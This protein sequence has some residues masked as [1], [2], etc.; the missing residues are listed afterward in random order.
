M[1]KAWILIFLALAIISTPLTASNLQAGIPVPLEKLIYSEMSPTL[2]MANIFFAKVDGGLNRFPSNWKDVEEGDL[3]RSPEMEPVKVFRFRSEG[4]EFHYVV[5]DGGQRKIESLPVLGFRPYL[6]GLLFADVSVSLRSKSATGTSPINLPYQVILSEKEGYAYSRIAEY[7]QGRIDLAGTS[8]VVQLHHSGPGEF[9]FAARTSLCLIDQNHDEK[10]QIG[11]AVQADGTLLESESIN[12]G[13]PFFLGGKPWRSGSL[14][15]DGAGWEIIPASEKFA[16]AVGFPAPPF[17]FRD[18]K[19]RSGRLDQYAGKI[20]LIQFWSTNCYWSK[21]IR[22]ELNELIA[23]QKEASFA[24]LAVA[25]NSGTVTDIEAFLTQT[26]MAG[27]IVV[28]E[29]ASL[30]SFNPKPASP[31]FYLIDGQGVIRHVGSGASQVPILRK[32][33]DLLLKGIQP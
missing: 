15:P 14:T 3:F 26:P 12:L 6:K 1:N 19:N 23:G 29:E 25:F 18:L 10:Y 7:R 24:A 8:F 32:K 16:A 31:L 28:A 13:E 27:N 9:R 2:G 20:V 33:I 21:T 11:D 22:P 5:D 4:V 17:A 30:R